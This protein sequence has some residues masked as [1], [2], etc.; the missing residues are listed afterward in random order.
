MTRLQ[1]CPSCSSTNTK[2]IESRPIRAGARRRRHCCNSCDHRWTSYA[3]AQGNSIAPPP[4]VVPRAP[5]PPRPHQLR[6]SEAD[7]RLILQSP[8]RTLNS[9]AAELGCS[10]E[11]VRQ[12]RRGLSYIDV[13][14]EL[15][16]QGARPAPPPAGAPS[17]LRCN[18]WQNDDCGIG[19]PDP[20]EEGPGFAADCDLYAA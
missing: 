9:L 1:H 15:P 18:H 3:D 20:L 13:H 16:R 5:Q 19:F 14:P 2:T 7:V 10:R 17:C 11:T 12:V 4:P 6:F 8:D